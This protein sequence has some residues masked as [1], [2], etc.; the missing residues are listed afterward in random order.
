MEDQKKKIE[1]AIVLVARIITERADGGKYL[2]VYNRLKAEKMALSSQDDRLEEIRQ[3]A[4][5]QRQAA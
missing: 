2:P 1:E 3:I 5:G 4:E